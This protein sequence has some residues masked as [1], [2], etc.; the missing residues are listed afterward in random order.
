MMKLLQ[1]IFS[2]PQF[3]SHKESQ[4][5]WQLDSR[6]IG[7]RSVLYPEHFGIRTH[8]RWKEARFFKKIFKTGEYSKPECWIV[9]LVLL[10]I[11]NTCALWIGDKPL[12][13]G[14][15]L[16]KWRV[17]NW[18]ICWTWAFTNIAASP[19]S[20]CNSWVVLH[21]ISKE[22]ICLKNQFQ[23]SRLWILQKGHT[24]KYL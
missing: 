8:I 19:P 10:F 18:R 17:L 2:V 16:I 12:E 7:T 23:E 6:T 24:W 21:I 22:N 20:P 9:E 15:K 5:V 14:A 4:K 1:L 3:H 11:F 13:N